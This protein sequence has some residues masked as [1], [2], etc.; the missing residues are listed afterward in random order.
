MSDIFR[1]ARLITEDPNIFNDHILLEGDPKDR[2]WEQIVDTEVVKNL[3]TL[4][5]GTKRPSIVGVRIY[6]KDGSYWSV[7]KRFGTW[8]QVFPPKQKL[9][10]FF[11]PMFDKNHMPVMLDSREVEWGD[12]VQ[13]KHQLGKQNP[14]L[15]E[16]LLDA[17]S[18]T[19]LK[20]L[21]YT[22][23]APEGEEWYREPEDYTHHAGDYAP[24]GGWKW[25]DDI[26]IYG[27][28]TTHSRKNW[29]KYRKLP[30]QGESTEGLEENPG[31]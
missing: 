14:R 8:K 27:K 16:A 21:C 25:E 1:I 26:R 29:G 12:T 6:M 28:G 20:S 15:L 5:D 3:I 13:V 17:L 23:D 4:K 9:D 7:S 31:K 19:P 18:Q 30:S 11:K 2:D 24:E 22:Q 10:K